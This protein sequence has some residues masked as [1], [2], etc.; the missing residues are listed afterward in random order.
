MR[1]KWEG[2]LGMKERDVKGRKE[3]IEG[4]RKRNRGWEI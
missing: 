1:G 3:E 2:T 4:L